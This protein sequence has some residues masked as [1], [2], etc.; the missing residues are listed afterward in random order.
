MT[1][2]VYIVSLEPIDTRYT[3]QWKEHIPKSLKSYAKQKNKQINVVDI[4]GKQVENKTTPGAF[5]DFAATNIWKSSQLE[6]IAELFR[7]RKVQAGDVFV[8]TD[9][10]NPAVIQLKYMS[11]LLQIP[12]KIIGI[13]HAG[14]YDPQDFLGRLIGDAPWVRTFEESLYH[15]FDHLVFATEFHRKMFAET[16]LDYELDWQTYSPTDKKK[17]V[18]SGFPM[19]YFPKLLEPYSKLPKKDLILFPHRIAPEKQVNIFKDLA[20]QL[21]EYEWIICQEK[22]LSKHEYHTL[23]GQSKMI[24]SANLQETLGIGCIEAIFSNSMPAVPDR[25]SYQEMYSEFF[26]YPSEWTENW[27]SYE[28]NRE[29]LVQKIKYMMN[30]YDTTGTIIEQQK[31]IL[32]DKFINPEIMYEKVLS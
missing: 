1:K 16:I 22:Q 24:F 10:W 32:L 19:E 30:H 14:S 15:T 8:Y 5:L 9:F 12:V 18:R 26:K 2:N 4:S 31:K 27:E 25:L 3:A 7:D 20:K 17:L 21:P 13:A 6:K 28:S 29:Q 23:L 11:E